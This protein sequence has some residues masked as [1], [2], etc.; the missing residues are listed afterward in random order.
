METSSQVAQSL[1]AFLVGLVLT[2]LL[3][4]EGVLFDRGRLADPA[5]LYT[6]NRER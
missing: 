4:E 6:F 5:R 2:G 1:G 3:A